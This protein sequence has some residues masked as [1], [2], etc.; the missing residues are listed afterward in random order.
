MDV[1]SFVETAFL[2]VDSKPETFS[3]RAPRR[4]EYSTVALARFR[5]VFITP[6]KTGWCANQVSQ[7][8]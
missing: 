3:R 2:V 4:G 5:N 1:L 7:G 6:C 8:S